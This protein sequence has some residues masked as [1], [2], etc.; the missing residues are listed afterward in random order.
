[1]TNILLISDKHQYLY[2]KL[3]ENFICSDFSSEIEFSILV[4]NDSS[5]TD[6]EKLSKNIKKINLIKFGKQFFIHYKGCS[7]RYGL[8]YNYN[9]ISLIKS[10]K[11]EIIFKIEKLNPDLIITPNA[12]DISIRIIRRYL[13]D[14]PVYYVQHS[15]IQK[16]LPNYGLRK[17]IWNLVYEKLTGV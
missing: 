9:S 13:P 4:R 15:S 7:I 17:K 2:K 5:V 8:E 11:Q 14:I 1:M 12:D 6:L 16:N 3:F 10:M